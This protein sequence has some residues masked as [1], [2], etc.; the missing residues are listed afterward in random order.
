MS[1][2]PVAPNVI[3][4]QYV[5]GEDSRDEKFSMFASNIYKD[6]TSILIFVIT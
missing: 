5:K 6:P 3:S 2:V 1:Y 4:R